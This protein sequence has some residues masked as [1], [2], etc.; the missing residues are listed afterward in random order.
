MLIEVAREHLC[1][2]LM[3]VDLALGYKELWQLRIKNNIEELKLI[4]PEGSLK[5]HM[6]MAR[7]AG[8]KKVLRR[9]HPI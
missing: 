5:V 7:Y 6:C 1:H 8:K 9:V 4:L 2:I 3:P